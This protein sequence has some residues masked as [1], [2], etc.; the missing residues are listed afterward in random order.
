MSSRNLYTL[1]GSEFT[2]LD[3]V[4]HFSETRPITL[5]VPFFAWNN[6]QL[7][8][9]ISKEPSEF[10]KILIFFYRFEYFINHVWNHGIPVGLY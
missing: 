1:T 8:L 9:T 10:L 5:Q 3:A 6:T 7:V 4:R 2:C